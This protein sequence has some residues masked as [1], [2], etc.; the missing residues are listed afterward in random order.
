VTGE[1]WADWDTY[2]DYLTIK[3]YYN[4]DTA[5]TR[6]YNGPG[7]NNDKAYAIAVD[8]S[9]NV[10]VTGESTGMTTW[11]DLATIKYNPEGD[12]AWIR[13]YGTGGWDKAN[14]ISV[15]NAGNVYVTGFCDGFPGQEYVTVKYYANGDTAWV[16]KYNGPEWMYDEEQ[17]FAIAVDNPGNVYVTGKL[18]VGSY[19]RTDYCTIKYYPNGDTAWVRR[20]D[21]TGNGSAEA[22]AIAVDGSGNVYVTGYS[23]KNRVQYHNY[24]YATIK[25]YPNGD[26]GWA[27]IYNGPRDSADFAYAIAVDGYGNVY[28]TGQS[29]QFGLSAYDFDYVTIRYY[30]NG[31]TAWVRRYNGLYSSWDVA[32]AIAIDGLG[33]VYVTGKSDS[34]ATIKYHQPNDP[35]NPFSLIFPRQKAFVPAEVRF[36]WETATD[37]NPSDQVRYDLYLSTSY[38]FP[39]GQTDIDSNLTAS[40]FSKELGYNVYY[41]KVKAKDNQGAMRWSS[42]IR[43]LIVTDFGYVLGDVNLDK[44]INVADV[45]F[46]VNYLFISGPAPNPLDV[47]DVN[48]DNKVNSADVV[49]LINYLYNHGPAPGC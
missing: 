48:C 39:P 43:Q 26:T 37:P 10:Y 30:P 20:Y 23:S 19:G 47:G 21:G 22:R 31:D 41:W 44:S 2:L 5:W 8:D 40:E 24:D 6:R 16:R 25:Y 12:T 1:S 29:S 38:Q 15:D 18:T 17:A 33:N 34:Y 42:Q 27:R 9:G 28:V 3:Y 35:P 49:F 11:L 32:R 36:E 14:A 4:G 46:L 13:R 45:S 7:N